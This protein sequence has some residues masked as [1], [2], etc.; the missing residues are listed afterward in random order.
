M[1]QELA[2]GTVDANEPYLARNDLVVTGSALS[3]AEQSFASPERALNSPGP[4]T[5]V[6]NL[7]AIVAMAPTGWISL[8]SRCRREYH[9]DFGQT[10][11]LR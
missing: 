9:R 3:G 8:W 10:P 7:F 4:N 2:A 1:K 5:S 11:L 6:L